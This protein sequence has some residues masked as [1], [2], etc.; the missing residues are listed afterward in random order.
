MHFL[1]IYPGDPTTP[2]F[3][4]YENATRVVGENIPFI[5][6][7]PISWANAQVLL[8]EIQEGGA[9]RT[10][11]LANHGV[12]TYR[13]YRPIPDSLVSTVDQKVTPIWNVMA[14][15]PG[16]IKDEVVVVGNHRDGMFTH[17]PFV[18]HF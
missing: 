16:H 7:L 3:P 2:G 15:I 12:Q 6:S 14:Y 5:P 17:R 1:S 18:D 4:S 9:N 8:R 13:L 11:R 10:I